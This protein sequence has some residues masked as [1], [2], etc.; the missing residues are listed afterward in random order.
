MTENHERAVTPIGECRPG[1]KVTITGVVS[2]VCLH[3]AQRTPSL[4]IDVADDTGHVTVVW[5][6]RR[7]IPGIDA[8]RRITVCGRM[9]RSADRCIIFNPTY[10]LAPWGSADV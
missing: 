2:S 10:R 3:P 7:R 1:T 4:E 9:T 6:G 8:G 5:L